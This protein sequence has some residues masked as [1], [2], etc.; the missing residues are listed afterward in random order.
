MWISAEVAPS[1]TSGEVAASPVSGGVPTSSA[2][3]VGESPT[4]R[5]SENHRQ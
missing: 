4:T 1:A 2:A 5:L 3:Q